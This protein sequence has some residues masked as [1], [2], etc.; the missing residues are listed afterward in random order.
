MI[1]YQILSIRQPWTSAIAFGPKRCENR[2][3]FSS[4]RGPLALHAGKSKA[5]LKLPLLRELWGGGSGPWPAI[6]FDPAQY[7]LGCVLATCHMIDCCS[8][9]GF[10]SKYADRFTASHAYFVDGPWCF[11]L[12][13][14]QPLATPMP[15]AGQLN[16]WNDPAVD[17]FIHEQR[18]A[19]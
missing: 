11:V 14:V 5:T 7:P 1:N 19:A 12:A 6:S 17:R 4:Y 2:T 9:E 13:R 16:L 8:P 15:L 10:R 3:W 18:S